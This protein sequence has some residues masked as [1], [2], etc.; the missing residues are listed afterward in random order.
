M[1]LCV[2]SQSLRELSP[3]LRLPTLLQRILPYI[4]Y[5]LYVAHSLFFFRTYQKG[6]GRARHR[7]TGRERKQPRQCAEPNSHRYL[8]WTRVGDCGYDHAR[9]IELEP[10][11]TH[12]ITLQTNY[13]L[14]L[15]SNLSH[16]QKRHSAI[17]SGTKPEGQCCLGSLMETRSYYIQKRRGP[18]ESPGRQGLARNHTHRHAI[19]HSQEPD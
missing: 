2:S 19:S 12:R 17:S 3:P 16:D 8:A 10:M 4:M 6:Q 11:Y 7:S 5:S 13:S 9:N 15:S 1:P 14:K 18:T